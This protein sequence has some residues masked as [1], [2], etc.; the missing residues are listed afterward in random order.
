M[1]KKGMLVLILAAVLAGS[2]FAQEGTGTHKH[3]S[4]DMVL[5]LN[6]GFGITP[7]IGKVTS[8]EEGNYAITTDIGL[9]YDFYLFNWLSF[10]TGAVLHSDVYLLLDQDLSTAQKF[11]DIA[12]TPICLTLPLT[13]HINV[14]WIEWLYVGAGLN[15]NIPIASLLNNF[16][17]SKGDFFVSLPIDIGFDFMKAGGN[18]GRFIFRISPEFHERGTTVPVGFVWQLHN[19]KIYGKN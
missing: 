15:L 17:D 5:G 10:N 13:A 6:M 12:S 1:S 18:G 11:T 19:W 2:V 8:L 7:N 4:F 3:Q 16:P 14:P 9:N